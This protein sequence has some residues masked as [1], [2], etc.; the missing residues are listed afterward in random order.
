MTQSPVEGYAAHMTALHLIAIP[1]MLRVLT[2]GGMVIPFG[3][4]AVQCSAG[5]LVERTAW[6]WPCGADSSQCRCLRTVISEC[7][8]ERTYR[9][10]FFESVHVAPLLQDVHGLPIAA[11]AR[12]QKLLSVHDVFGRLH[13]QACNE[14]T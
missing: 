13:L 2:S 5:N 4:S 1:D 8:I 3:M 12:K 14:L 11:H 6:C 9:D 10:V 7:L